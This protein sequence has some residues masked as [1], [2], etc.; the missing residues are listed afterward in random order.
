MILNAARSAAA[1]LS[2]Y[3][4]SMPEHDSIAAWLLGARVGDDAAAQALWERYWG[5]LVQLAR[6]KLPAHVKRAFDEEDV[7]HSALRCFLRGMAQDRYP[8]LND[9]HGLWNLLVVI[10]ARKARAYL[11]RQNRQKRGGGA[12][13]GETA[14]VSPTDDAQGIDQVIGA[15]PS[16]EFAA[17]VA[18]ECQRLLD[19]LDD[20]TL[21]TIALLKME[22]HTVDEIAAQLGSTKRTIERRLHIIRKTWE[23]SAANP[24]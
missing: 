2:R 23:Q 9:R 10:T 11:T 15:E 1:V 21:K 5:R 6:Q 3:N 14:F 19:Q 24:P 13:L 17:Q 16:P 18:E 8:Q 4:L 22:G 20:A 12:V 7:A